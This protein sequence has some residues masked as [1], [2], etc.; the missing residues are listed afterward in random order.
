MRTFALAMG[1]ALACVAIISLAACNCGQGG[2][3]GGSSTCYPAGETCI[4]FD[5]LALDTNYH[6]GDSLT[7][8]RTLL[9]IGPF[10]WGNGTWTFGNMAEVDPGAKAG[11]SGNSLQL[12]NVDATFG[13]GCA[14]KIS[15]H[16]GEYGGNVNLRVNGDFR[17]TDNFSDLTN[18]SVGGANIVVTLISP[19]GEHNEFAVLE[20]TG[21]ITDFALGGQELWIDDVCITR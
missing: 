9:M 7:E 4:D 15:V 12:N 21:T 19:A 20:I 10:Q 16:Y 2:S 11:G 8:D 14:T 6:N 5:A 18:S 17:N 13:V 3:S 1:K